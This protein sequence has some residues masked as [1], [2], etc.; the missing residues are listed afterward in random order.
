MSYSWGD[1][2]RSTPTP[3]SKGY[4]YASARKAYTDP[5]PK[6]KSSRKADRDEDEDA[7][8]SA[9]YGSAK[10]AKAKAKAPVGRNVETDSTHPIVVATDVT[11]SMS[12]WPKIIFE[13]APLLGK[14]VERYAP[15]YAISFAAFGDS[16]CDV[17]PLQVRD[18]AKGEALDEHIK[19][20]YPEGAGG[21]DPESHNVVAY[22]YNEHCKIE[23]AVKPIF[24]LITDTYSHDDLA[25]YE[26]ENC[27]GDT[28]SRLASSEIFAKLA[29]KFSVYVV[30]KGAERRKYWADIFGEQRV[31]VMEEPR[32]VVEI[33]IGII[34]GEVGELKDFEMRS[35]KRHEDKPDR[36]SRVMKSLK[37]EEG[38]S[39]E[40]VD[41]EGKATASK[42]SK[43]C[44]MKSKKLV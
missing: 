44:A 17:Y 42:R 13:K 43:S 38:A 39:P 18:F 16:R 3:A 8:R 27:T 9:S 15:N 31:V 30:L 40:G 26:I 34:A 1:D 24:I 4:D 25:A 41:G 7:D 5:T 35:S 21:D 2:A 12:A 23:K 19:A 36:I 32:D 20:L 11:G 10:S 28:S 14:E 33:L 37:V 29:N 22:Y 6:A